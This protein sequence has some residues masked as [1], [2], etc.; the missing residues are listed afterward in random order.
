LTRRVESHPT[1]QPGTPENTAAKAEFEKYLPFIRR[2]CIEE[3][4]FYYGDR[5][6]EDQ[7]ADCISRCWRAFRNWDAARDLTMAYLRLI[8][9]R[10]V[11]TRIKY[12]NAHRHEEMMDSYDSHAVFEQYDHGNDA[13]WMA[14]IK[15]ECQ[16]ILSVVGKKDFAFAQWWVHGK[17]IGEPPPSWV[18]PNRS[19]QWYGQVM[20]S[21]VRRVKHKLS[22]VK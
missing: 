12:E 6:T 3:Y 13:E 4:K 9:G 20:R 15:D 16:H 22:I 2:R 7:H 8:V 1:F 14:S 11:L 17:D 10:V 18:S 5:P 19:R 21:V